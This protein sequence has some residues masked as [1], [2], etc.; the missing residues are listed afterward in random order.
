M[1]QESRRQ[2]KTTIAGR[3]ARGTGAGLAERSPPTMDGLT[4]H[5]RGQVH[6][7]QEC[8]VARVVFQALQQWVAFKL[9]ETAVA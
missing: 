1:E 7:L 9:R 6:L 8:G 4:S 3:A 2:R 5:L